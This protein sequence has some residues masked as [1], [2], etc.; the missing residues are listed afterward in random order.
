V[1]VDGFC[2]ECG[3]NTLE[4]VGEYDVGGVRDAAGYLKC[5]NAGCAD[6]MAATKILSDP[7]TH[8]VVKLTPDSF[9]VVHPLRERLAHELLD[10]PLTA[11]L[12]SLPAP[13]YPPGE[14]RVERRATHTGAGVPW[15]FMSVTS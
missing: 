15:T 4:A 3:L 8:H 6:P 2:P 7:E 1:R 12:A 14:Y 10:C 5:S 13:P 9:S 11:W